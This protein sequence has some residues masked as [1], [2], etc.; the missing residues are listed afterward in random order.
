MAPLLL[1]RLGGT[2]RLYKVCQD[3]A[4]NDQASPVHLWRRPEGATE[5]RIDATCRLVR[6]IEA[7]IAD[8]NRSI[9]YLNRAVEAEQVRTGIADP[10]HF[11]YS[12]AA[13]AMIRRRSNLIQ[14][15]ARL[16]RQLAAATTTNTTSSRTVL[17]EPAVMP[18]PQP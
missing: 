3:G 7:A 8:F 2:S 15:I 9:S 11:A 12:T 13:Q 6:Q 17:I 10:N 16:K 18:L 4:A 5:F 1:L 14:S